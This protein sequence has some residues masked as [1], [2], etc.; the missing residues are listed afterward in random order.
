[1][2]LVMYFSLSVSLGLLSKFWGLAEF[3][4]ISANYDIEASLSLLV[5]VWKLS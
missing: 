2:G 4:K 1:M 3:V 5:F